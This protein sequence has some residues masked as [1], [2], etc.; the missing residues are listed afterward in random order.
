MEV[1]KYVFWN[2]G[3]IW[4]YRALQQ[5][6]MLNC[7]FWWWW[8]C[9]GQ[10]GSCW[11]AV[12]NRQWCHVQYDPHPALTR[13][14][15]WL[16]VRVAL[17]GQCKPG[18]WPH[19]NI[20]HWWWM[21]DHILRTNRDQVT[22]ACHCR[23]GRGRSGRQWPFRALRCVAMVVYGTIDVEVCLVGEQEVKNADLGQFNQ[24]N[25]IGYYWVHN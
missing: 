8:W 22:H 9:R 16:G 12:A 15:S 23:P 17:V 24:S 18:W 1:L 20:R 13:P 2:S 14:Y 11:R 10:A 4:M 3:S 19:C 25:I 5:F 21:S 7:L 6:H